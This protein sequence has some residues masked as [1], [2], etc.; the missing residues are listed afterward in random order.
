MYFTYII[1]IWNSPRN[2]FSMH[3][4]ISSCCVCVISTAKSCRRF[5]L[6]VD[7]SGGI[8]KILL[9]STFIGVLE[10][11]LKHG[12]YNDIKYPLYTSSSLL[13]GWRQTVY[14][15]QDTNPSSFCKVTGYIG[16]WNW[17]TSSTVG[18]FTIVS[19]KSA[20]SLRLVDK[21][22]NAIEQNTIL[23]CKKY[24][25]SKDGSRY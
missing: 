13:P 1:T 5:L 23:K 21:F 10:N 7:E 16:I 3:D 15:A 18:F 14:V 24:T 8:R 6:Y 22:L 2:M 20:L 9:T 11:F 17:A 25:H 19:R 12:R 4:L